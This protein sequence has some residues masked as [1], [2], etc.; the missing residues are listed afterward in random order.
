MNI[1]VKRSFGL[2]LLCC[3]FSIGFF[4]HCDKDDDP[5]KND[6]DTFYLKCKINGVDWAAQDL[7]NKE[8]SDFFKINDLPTASIQHDTLLIAGAAKVGNDT[9]GL[10]M[11]AQLPDSTNATGTYTFSGNLLQAILN[12][13]LAI[14]NSNKNDLLLY[15][16]KA[17]QLGYSTDSKLVV[18]KHAA[19]KMDGTFQF[20][21]KQM[22]NDS[23]IFAIS[24]GEFKNLPVEK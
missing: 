6:D 14:Y 12:K 4:T 18:T 9:T 2:A 23:T 20:A 10:F 1:K 16:S 7:D 24:N 22:S 13:S 15:F 17:S 5:K 8:L 19:N 21:I 3:V 11:L